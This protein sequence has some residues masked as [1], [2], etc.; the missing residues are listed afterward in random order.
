MVGNQYQY[1]WTTSQIKWQRHDCDHNKSIYQDNQTQDDSHD[2]IVRG[3]S[4]NLQK[5]NIEDI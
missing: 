4:Q 1:H 2:S 3:Y 5:W